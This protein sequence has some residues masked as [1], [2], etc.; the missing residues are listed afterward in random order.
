MALANPR[1]R[2]AGSRV[3]PTVQDGLVQ[4]RSA[5][6]L[7]G[8]GWPT[9]FPLAGRQT[10]KSLFEG[11]IDIRNGLVEQET[12]P[13]RTGGLRFRHN[14][15]TTLEGAMDCARNA[16]VDGSWLLSTWW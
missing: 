9:P 13:G 12:R 6:R 3:L 5:R 8:R 1:P 11:P 14:V 10:K 15:P 2:S 4:G 16:E 7:T